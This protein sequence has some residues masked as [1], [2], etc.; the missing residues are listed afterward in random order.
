MWNENPNAPIPKRYSM[1]EKKRIGENI[2]KY[3][4]KR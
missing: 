4:V 3:E 1:Q 2:R